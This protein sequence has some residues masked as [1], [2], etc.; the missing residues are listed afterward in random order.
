MNGSDNYEENDWFY[1]ILDCYWH[2][3]N[4]FYHKWYIGDM[5]YNIMSCAWI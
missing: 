3:Y 5:Y 2:D 1:S 4:A